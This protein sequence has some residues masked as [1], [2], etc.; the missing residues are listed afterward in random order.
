MR[1][2]KSMFRQ[3]MFQQSMFR[4]SP[5]RPG[6]LIAAI[7]ASLLAG[8]SGSETSGIGATFGNLLAFNSTTAPAPV[9]VVPEA[10][11]NLVCP[12][13]EVKEGGAAQRV[14][15]GGQESR[16]VRHQFSLGELA[17]ECRVAGNQLIMKVG[18]EGKVLLGPAGSPAS[19][20]VPVT[21][22]VIAD[23]SGKP[24]ASRSYKASASIPQGQSLSSF[25]IVSD[26]IS[27]P[28]ISEAANTDYSI[29][30]SID[31]AGGRR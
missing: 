27:V 24:A 29:V 30:V 3:S 1:L 13:I 26:H 7:A 5:L 8:C 11:K 17:R 15:A 6:V 9:A 21:I 12:G 19:F 18:V 25:T 16:N 28:F 23:E 10:P 20:T 4:R 14:Y 2:Q 31:G 22:A